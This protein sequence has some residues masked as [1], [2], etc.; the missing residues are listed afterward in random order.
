MTPRLTAKLA[1]GAAWGAV[2]WLIYGTVELILSSGIQ[3]WR[4][5][6]MEILGWQWRLIAML[7]AAYAAVGLALGAIAGLVAPAMPQR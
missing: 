2:A 7:M 6:E 1:R 5:P 3:L 4:F